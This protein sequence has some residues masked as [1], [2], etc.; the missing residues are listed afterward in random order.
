MIRKLTIHTAP[1]TLRGAEEEVVQTLLTSRGVGYSVQTHRVQ[2]DRGERIIFA[3]SGV[4][5]YRSPSGVSCHYS[6]RFEFGD[7]ESITLNLAGEPHHEQEVLSVVYETVGINRL[8]L[9]AQ[10]GEKPL[11]AEAILDFAIKFLTILNSL[12]ERT[13]V[14]FSADATWAIPVLFTMEDAEFGEV[15]AE[16][17]QLTW[18]IHMF[19][20]AKAGKTAQLAGVRL[21]TIRAQTLTLEEREERS[22]LTGASQI[23]CTHR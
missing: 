21:V 8:Y 3:P 17:I 15:E 18:L 20:G 11:A 13:A 19:K 14:P 16:G 9:G 5:D 2:V 6:R 10:T 7:G 1:L 12:S 4:E 23:G 22:R